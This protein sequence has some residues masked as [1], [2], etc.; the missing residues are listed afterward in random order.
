MNPGTKPRRPAADAA[1]GLRKKIT[2]AHAEA[3]DRALKPLDD[4]IL[5]ALADSQRE[6]LKFLVKRLGTREDA[7]DAL[8]DFYVKVVR[9][10]PTLADDSKIDA[11][12]SQILRNTLIDHYRRRA[13][14]KRAEAAFHREPMSTMVNP[15]EEF[16]AIACA[17]LY[18]LL[19]TLKPVYAEI[20]W[21]ADLLAQPREKIAADLGVTVNNV[22][23]RLHRARL[24]LKKRLEQTCLT[25]TTHGFLNCRC[26]IAKRCTAA[27]RVAAA[28]R[29][30]RG[31]PASM[32]R[33]SASGRATRSNGGSRIGH[34]PGARGHSG[35]TAP[36]RSTDDW[37]NDEPCSTHDGPT[38]RHQCR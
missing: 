27:L 33:E 24:A 20:L 37:G 18:R 31:V 4:A 1:T 26:D 30:E 25:C 8:Q 29:K 15:D 22:G 32:N 19:P 2:R 14:R 7:E 34:K 16:D 11:W 23:I 13:A 38:A 3:V 35:A 10:A 5:V 12:L 21:R 28:D 6:F 36:K 17:C 9:N